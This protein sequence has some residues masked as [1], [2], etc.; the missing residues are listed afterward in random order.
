MPKRA[1]TRV[2]I[3][4]GA[5]LRLRPTLRMI[6]LVWFWPMRGSSSQLRS[7]CCSPKGSTRSW[8]TSVRAVHSPVLIIS[9]VLLAVE[10]RLLLLA[11]GPASKLIKDMSTSRKRGWWCVNK[12]NWNLQF[13]VRANVFQHFNVATLS[14]S[15]STSFPIEHLGTLS[16]A[17]KIDKTEMNFQ[18]NSEGWCVVCSQW[19]KR[20]WMSVEEI[21][22][23]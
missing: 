17:N 6:V 4:T 16:Q 9:Q 21:V 7:S 20:L 5:L 15:S 3:D 19:G 22:K 10:P 13:Y 14:A 11:V 2:S 8:T 1:L 12:K 18:T 23:R